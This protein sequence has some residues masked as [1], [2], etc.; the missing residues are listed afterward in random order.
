MTK[1]AISF[2]LGFRKHAYEGIYFAKR[3]KR[4]KYEYLNLPQQFII[5]GDLTHFVHVDY[6]IIPRKVSNSLDIIF[7][8]NMA[9]VGLGFVCQF[10][11]FLSFIKFVSNSFT[12]H[13]NHK[14]N[15]HYV[16]VDYIGVALRLLMK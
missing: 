5:C 16:E 8:E 15:E 9:I 6:T 2:V 1:F 4:R 14:L 11:N 12:P 13:L 3:R 7:Y 10:I